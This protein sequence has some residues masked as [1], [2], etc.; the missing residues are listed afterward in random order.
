MQ[1][2]Q[3]KG[4]RLNWP[5]THN[6]PAVDCLKSDVNHSSFEFRFGH[7]AKVLKQSSHTTCQTVRSWLFIV[8]S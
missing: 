7:A 2:M 1:E 5:L 6:T 8:V 3:E 4:Q